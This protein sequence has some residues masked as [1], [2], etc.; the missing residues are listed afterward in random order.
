MD[1]HA[2]H[3]PRNIHQLKVPNMATKK[4]P[5]KKKSPAKKIT[6]K[7]PAKKAE[8]LPVE[9]LSDEEAE[10]IS[11]RIDWQRNQ[12]MISKAYFELMVRKREEPTLE[13]LARETGL[14]T[15]TIHRHQNTKAFT[16]VKN[17]L[18]SVS[19]AMIGKFIAA[20]AS[21]KNHAMWDLFFTVTYEEFAEAKKN[22][23]ID[24]TTG[25]EKIT[26][27]SKLDI[28]NLTAEQLQTLLDIREKAKK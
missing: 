21:S 8:A 10:S 24:L 11:T 14:S 23:K 15:K 5:A 22:K 27:P 4:A 25:G 2:S 6:K 19:D 9:E 28:G 20:V 13:A 17:H 26:E 16:E 18:K 1:Q 3:H 12:S 7:A